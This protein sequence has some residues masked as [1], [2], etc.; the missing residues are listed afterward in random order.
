MRNNIENIKD[1]HDVEN[2]IMEVPKFT[3]T[4]SIE[5]TNAFYTF[6]GRPGERCHVIHVAGTNGKG[7][8]SVFMEKMLTTMGKSVGLFTSPH[9]VSITE[10][11]RYNG[12]LSASEDISEEDFVRLFL[13]M[14]EK[15]EAF[16]QNYHPTFFEIFF[17]V[18]MLYYEE[19]K[20][21]FIILETG[22]GGRLDATNVVSK[23]IAV[24]TKIAM[25]HMEYLG[26][27][28]EKIA[29]EKAGIIEYNKPVVF[30]DYDEGVSSVIL[31]KADSSNSNAFA[32]NNNQYKQVIKHKNSIDFLYNFQYYGYCE[33]SVP[34]IA[35]YQVVNASVALRAVEVL[36]GTA[37]TPNIAKEAILKMNWPCRMEMISDGIYIDGAHNPDG[38]EALVN[39]AANVEGRKILL[40]AVVNDKDYNLMLKQIADS[41]LFEEVVITSVGGK[42]ATNESAIRDMLISLGQPQVCSYHEV[43]DAYEYAVSIK[44]NRTLV[45]AGS[46]YLAGRIRELCMEERHD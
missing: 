37:L 7:S 30:Y 35:D 3:K 1:L 4:N 41:R 45:I 44:G 46:L 29:A 15:T 9:L 27:T 33:L 6:L 31:Q 42:R 17:L 26:D 8:V 40:F 10:R 19:K 20:P 18:A 22:L 5:T 38:I 24:I 12:N 32:V 16:A 34:T 2:Y 14:M 11:I 25:D 28:I 39:A 13:Y 43:E 23:D 21:D 36:I